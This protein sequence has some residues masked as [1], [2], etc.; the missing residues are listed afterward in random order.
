MKVDPTRNI[1]ELY[2]GLPEVERLIAGIL[3][4]LIQ[5]TL[6][7]IREKLSWGAPFYHGRR[8]VCFVWPASIPW[9]K[10]TEGVA[11]GFSRA[12]ELNHDGWLGKGNRKRIGRHI[13]HQPEEIDVE[14]VIDLLQQ[15]WAI[16][17]T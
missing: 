2:D 7:D 4:D 6:P 11:L 16:D 8:S 9:G 15:A 5:E 1:D 10:L 14:R 12:N 3:R 17:Q 13:F